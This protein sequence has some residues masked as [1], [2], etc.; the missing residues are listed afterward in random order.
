MSGG[1]GV[2][3]EPTDGGDVPPADASGW[4]P[5]LRVGSATHPGYRRPDNQ[6]GALVGRRVF[7]VA[8]GMGGHEDGAAASAAALRALRRLDADDGTDSD[9]PAAADSTAPPPGGPDVADRA[10]AVRAALADAHAAV[11]ALATGPDRA[12]GTTVTGVVLVVPGGQVPPAWLVVNV[13]DSRTYRWAHGALERLT[14]DDTLVAE[15]ER[16]GLLT[17]A[18]AR[19]DPRRHVITRALGAGAPLRP[20]PHDVRAVPAAPGDRVLSCSDGLTDELD[21]ARIAAL[22]AEGDDPQATAEALVAAALAAG[23]RDNVTVV[24]VDVT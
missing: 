21:D 20:G 13:G 2:G 5:H 4:R 22:L 23:G 11:A 1:V 17:A 9:V 12:P 14:G 7:L 3:D 6:D 10:A 24:V 19:S 8:D 15:L 16:A 18:E